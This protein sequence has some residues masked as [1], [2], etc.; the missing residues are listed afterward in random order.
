[1]TRSLENLMAQCQLRLENLFE[2]YLLRPNYSA[3]RL[4]QA[5]TYAIQNGGKR[6]RPLL[7]Y[8]TGQLFEAAAENLDAPACAIEFIHTYSLIHDDLPAM[9]NSDLRRGKPSC[10]KAFDEATAILAGDT[11]QSLAFD[12]LATHSNNLSAQQRIEMIRILGHASGI[13]GM[14]GGQAL[15]LAGVDSIETLN[16]M[17]HLKTGALLTA[18]VKMGMVASNIQ[19]THT[20]NALET[21]IENIGLAFQIQDDL[22]DVLGDAK[23]TGK[24]Q[25][26]D[27]LNQKITYPSLLGI[28]KTK[29]IIQQ[30][31]FS[32]LNKIEF[33]GNDAE[34]LRQLAY[35]LLQRKQ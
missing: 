25:G 8:A 27:N 5:M 1:M 29:E 32:A 18:S 4:Q 22:L 17:Y 28:E 24:P 30:L 21:Y 3:T 9:D 2:I 6:I 34:I 13:N 10:H 20:M 26:Q 12:A 16:H 15:D 19:D 31:F 33:L 14:A 7:V 11:L 23:T 35:H